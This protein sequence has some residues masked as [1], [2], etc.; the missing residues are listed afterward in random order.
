[1]HDDIVLEIFKSVA[2]A[3][4]RPKFI[5]ATYQ[6]KTYTMENGNRMTATQNRWFEVVSHNRWFLKNRHYNN[7]YNKGRNDTWT[8]KAN[9]NRNQSQWQQPTKQVTWWRMNHW[10]AW[11]NQSTDQ[12][13]STTNTTKTKRSKDN[14]QTNWRKW[15]F[16]LNVLY[17]NGIRASQSIKN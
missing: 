8:H 13:Y 7:T 15:F 3:F 17:H 6:R 10:S 4:A 2:P 5:W 16:Y 1:M 14:Q 12:K 9:S 11:K